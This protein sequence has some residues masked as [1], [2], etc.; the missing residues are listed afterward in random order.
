MRADELTAT[1][2]I[3]IDSAETRVRDALQ[4]EGFGVLTMIDVESTLREKLGV[5]RD[6]YRILGACNPALANESLDAEPDIGLLLP[7][8]VVL[9]SVPAGTQVSIVDPQFMALVT[10]NETL[11]DV[12]RRARAR[13][14][15][16]IKA[17]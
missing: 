3:D 1:L 7:C 12:A 5:E 4:A 16:V 10:E 6:P 13:L 17:L 8:N 2:G 9:R 11:A 14:T 15:E